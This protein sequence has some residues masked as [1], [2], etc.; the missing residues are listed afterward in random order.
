MRVAIGRESPRTISKANKQKS[1]EKLRH[2][3]I[4]RIILIDDRERKKGVEKVIFRYK[5]AVFNFCYQGC[6]KNL[7]LFG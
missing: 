4:M 2:T 5:C 3:I 6:V 7:D 1:N